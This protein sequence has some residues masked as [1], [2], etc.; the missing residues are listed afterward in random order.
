MA[1]EAHVARDINVALIGGGFMGK[2]H[3]VAY[4]TMPMFF[5][6]APAIP[7]RK[8]LADVDEKTALEAARRFG[9]ESASGDWRRAVDDPDVDLVDIATPNDL[10]FEIALAA[11]EAGKH[12][13]CEKPLARTADE[14]RQMVEAVERAG[15]VNMTAFNYRRTPAVGL[16]RKYIQEGAIGRI[17][18]FRGTYL[19]DWSAHPDAPR[20]WRFQKALAGSGAL[21]DIGTHVLDIARYLVGEVV[22]VNGLLQ[23]HIADRPLQQ[24]GLDMLAAAEKRGDAPRGVV[25]VDDEVHTLLRFSGGAAGSLECSRNAYGR[26]NFLTFEIHGEQGSIS[27]NYERRDELEVFFAE[28]AADRRGFRTVYAGPAHPYGD[29][30]WPLAGIGIGYAE[31]KIIECYELCRAIVEGSPASPDFADGYQVARIC[32]AVVQS[33]ETADWVEVPPLE[34]ALAD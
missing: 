24:D 7:R 20:S 21:G 23:T 10:H 27:F 32:D 25:D 14:A 34:R 16:A 13:I 15:V 28:D 26:N 9:Y 18:S 8:V 3:S 6:P 29:A 4:A 17:L 30:L 22:A 33:A 1:Q 5:W 31:T 19:Q 11:A 2:A 12:V